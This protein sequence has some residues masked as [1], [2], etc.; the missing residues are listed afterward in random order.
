M[1]QT[2]DAYVLML[3]FWY[4]PGID[5]WWEPRRQHTTS[6]HDNHWVQPQALCNHSLSQQPFHFPLEARKVALVRVCWNSNLR[7]QTE[8]FSSRSISLNFWRFCILKLPE[9]HPLT[10]SQSS[11]INTFTLPQ[12]RYKS[13][14]RTSSSR[15]MSTSIEFWG[16]EE[17]RIVRNI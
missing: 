7:G 17:K 5:P 15:I 1:C 11:F 13:G 12:K 2:I 3:L 6:L 8:F 14:N 10:N 9:D 4:S 16:N